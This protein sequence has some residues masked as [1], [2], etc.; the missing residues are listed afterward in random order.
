MLPRKIFRFFLARF[1]YKD[2][3]LKTWDDIKKSL[4]NIINEGNLTNTELSLDNEE[5][6]S[7]EECKIIYKNK[8]YILDDNKLYNI[9]NNNSKGEIYGSFINGKINKIKM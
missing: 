6:E 2:Q 5:S 7:D 3:I 8:T 1:N 4:D 9:N